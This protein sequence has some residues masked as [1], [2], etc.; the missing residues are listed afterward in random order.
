MFNTFRSI[1]PAVAV[2]ALFAVPAIAANGPQ[3]VQRIEISAPSGALLAAQAVLAQREVD[4]AYSMS[5]GRILKVASVGDS[6]HVQ[7]GRRVRASLQHDGHGSFVSRDGQLA[8]Q[9]QLDEAGDP[10]LVRLSLPAD[11]Q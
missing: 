5:T 1:I 9:F 8:L 4:T 2:A 11:W 3:D 7:Y 10:E 6:L